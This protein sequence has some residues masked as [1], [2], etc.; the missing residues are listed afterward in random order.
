M[1][2]N[3]FCSADKI[4]ESSRGISDSHTPKI[5]MENTE[6]MQYWAIGLKGSSPAISS[7]SIAIFIIN[8][9]VSRHK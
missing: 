9:S 6:L 4:K 7:P 2:K 8:S 3:I 1:S 5:V